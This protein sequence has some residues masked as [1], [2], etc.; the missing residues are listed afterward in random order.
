MQEAFHESERMDW[1][2]CLPK[3]LPV[4]TYEGTLDGCKAVDSQGKKYFC[5][6]YIVTS[7]EIYSGQKYTHW[8]NIS[9]SKAMWHARKEMLKFGVDQEDIELVS[10]SVNIKHGTRMSFEISQ[11]GN[12]QNCK[13]ISLLDEPKEDDDVKF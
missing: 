8:L 9:N 10:A 13:V 5:V 4:G 11:N 6:T 1:R 2:N 7:P 3:E 12:Y